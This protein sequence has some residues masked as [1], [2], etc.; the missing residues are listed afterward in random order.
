MAADGLSC[1]CGARVVGP[2]LVEPEYIVPKVAR[3][4]TALT[5]AV[6]SISAFT[7]KWMLVPA[8]IGLLLSRNAIKKNRLDPI[9]YGGR[10]MARL[11]MALSIIILAGVAVYVGIGIPKYLRLRA[12]SQRAA[13]RAQMYRVAIALHDYKRKHGAYPASL[14]A[15]QLEINEPLIFMDQWDNAL[16]YQATAEVAADAQNEDNQSVALTSFNEYVLVSPGPDGKL[17]T[18]DDMVMRDDIIISPTKAKIS[19][20]EES[21]EE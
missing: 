8:F 12:E 18:A 17:G 19:T 2:P 4:V 14:E 9:H 15:M 13:T 5:L 3:A 11:A 10:R 16:K 6:L 21:S 1:S 7:W 20:D